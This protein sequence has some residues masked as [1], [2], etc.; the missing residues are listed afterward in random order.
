MT[1]QPSHSTT[2]DADLPWWR[3]PMVWLVIGGPLVVVFAS[4]W[5][6]V[7]AIQH[8]DPVVPDTAR[9]STAGVVEAQTPAQQARNHA[10]TAR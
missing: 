4:I 6:L 8:P 5:T 7:L 3:H 1:T 2:A 10:A 9:R